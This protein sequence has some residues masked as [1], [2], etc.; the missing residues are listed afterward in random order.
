MTIGLDDPD[1]LAAL[2]RHV[3]GSTLPADRSHD[4]PEGLN[5]IGGWVVAL[6]Y[7]LGASIA[8]GAAARVDPMWPWAIA[9]WR[10]PSAFVHDATTGRWWRV[11]RWEGNTVEPEPILAGL[12]TSGVRDVRVRGLVP[13]V[14]PEQFGLQVERAVEY[15]RAGDVYQV[16]LSHPLVGRVRGS[17]RE[18]CARL[19]AR[20]GAW[21]GAYLEVAGGAALAG[22]SHFACSAS[23]E[24]FLHFDACTRRLTTRPIK[25]TR[26]D[27]PDAERDLRESGKDQAELNM[28]VDLMRNDLGRVAEFGSVRVEQ[29]REIERHGAGSVG[30]GVCG[31][32]RGK[33]LL[34]GVGT[35]SA[36]VREGLGIDDILRATFP[37]GSITGAPKLRAMQIIDDLEARPRGLYTGAIGFLSDNGSMTLSVAIRTAV[38]HAQGDQT[39]TPTPSRRCPIDHVEDGT[40]CYCAG[41]G[42]VVDSVPR[43]EWRETLDKARIMEDVASAGAEQARPEAR[44]EQPR[45]TRA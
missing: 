38:V 22:P 3:S 37:A 28:I 32:E 43:A 4:L 1:P 11:G 18:L 23:P 14:S 29:G 10:C 2:A 31:P 24:L 35:I 26:V 41:A 27:G 15:I 34:H 45:G 44:C 33:A 6:S 39:N 42:I 12:S 16:N 5:F 19:Q 9:L 17:M 20:S 36:R 21:Y 7:E 25:G 8:R 40:L 13:R 30:V